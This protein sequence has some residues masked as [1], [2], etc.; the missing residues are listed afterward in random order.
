MPAI[1]A[2]AHVTGGNADE[3]ALVTIDQ[4]GGGKAGVNLD[5]QR[6]GLCAQPARHQT[7]RADKIA[8]VVHQFW[9]GKIWQAHTAGW[10]KVEKPV[11]MDLLRQRAIRIGAPVRQQ[12]VK[13]DGVNHRAGKD[14]RANFPALFHH[15]NRDI[16]GNLF[17]P[18]GGGE[19]RRARPDDHHIIFHHLARRQIGGRQI[20]GW[21]GQLRRL[22]TVLVHI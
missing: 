15:D 4:F 13:A 14:M 9:H 1:A 16:R 2:D 22:E 3:L 21:H 11:F 8:V 17:E 12:P 20:I 7:E 6:F 18:D 19:T 5:A 10:A